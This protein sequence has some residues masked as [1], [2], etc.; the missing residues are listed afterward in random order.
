MRRAFLLFT[1]FVLAF[2]C[3]CT[4]FETQH[5]VASPRRPSED[6]R[7]FNVL[8]HI[9]RKYD[10]REASN[11]TLKG[12]P[13]LRADFFLAA[14]KD[15]VTTSAQKEQWVELMRQL[16][17]KARTKEINNLPAS[18]LKELSKKISMPADR[19]VLI[20][21]M[22][23]VS[24]EIFTHDKAQPKFYD[25]LKSVLA[26]PPKEYSTLQRVVGLCP[27]FTVP[28]IA[29]INSV[30]KEFKNW[31]KRPEKEIKI[32]GTLNTYTPPQGGDFATL[33]LSLMFNAAKRDAL[34]IP[35]L[36]N[37]EIKRL[38]ETFTPVFV[39]DTVDTYD[40]FAEVAWNQEG[41]V[42]INTD[43]PTVY[44]YPS[45]AFIKDE[46]VLQ[47]NYAIWYTGR[48]GP[49]APWMERGSLDGLTMRIT[50]SPSGEPI[51]LDIMNSCGCY[52]FYV[53]REDK[54]AGVTE[55]PFV[56]AGLP[57]KFPME[58]LSFRIK[59]GWHQV[60]HIST[61]EDIKESKTYDLIS[62]D[63][64]E[65]LPHPDGQR[66]NVFNSAGIMK[67]SQRIEHYFLFS[68]GIPSV[69]SMRQRGHHAISMVEEEN[70]SDPKIFDKNFIFK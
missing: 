5:F 1:V 45:Y 20:Q 51:M 6:Q 64:L 57:Q 24:Q 62:Y 40:R 55:K 18:A 67:D 9:V 25:T 22:S 28:I 66:E 10:V 43:K 50:I 7:F 70:F 47:M 16:D 52:H 44:Y 31:H 4:I 65:S 35:Q 49:N 53:P 60:E 29:G 54:V 69:G 13:Y 19:G 59:T 30:H 27:L 39:Q 42:S 17:L 61:S 15:R 32:L 68:L 46:P 14:L 41:H 21:K 26:H 48:S 12:F 23:E 33:D 37:D 8:D 63:V 38:A 2:S 34:G 58:R 11:F 36:T 3:G 56:V